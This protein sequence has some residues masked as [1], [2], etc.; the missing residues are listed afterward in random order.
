M[1]VVGNEHARARLALVGLHV[2]DAL[3][4]G[5]AALPFL[6]H[7]AFF[8]AHFGTF[9][10]VAPAFTATPK[11]KTLEVFGT[12]GPNG[13]PEPF[14][15]YSMRQ[16][17][18]EGFILDVLANYATYKAY[19]RL[20]KKV[21]DDPRYDKDALRTRLVETAFKQVFEDG[22]FHGDPH[23]GNVFYLPGNRIAFIDFGMVGRL[24]EERRSQMSQ[25]LLAFV[26]HEPARVADVMLDTLH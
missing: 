15:L 18:E 26:R 6:A 3:T 16:A 9:S 10:V 5:L 21:E 13:K 22:F 1:G 7:P 4:H 20:L 24:T 25:L 8:Y 23:P 17:I 14:H 11:Y 12:P 19:W 2:G